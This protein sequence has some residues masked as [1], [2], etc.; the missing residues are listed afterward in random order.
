MKR[1]IRLVRCG[2]VLGCL[3][4]T[5]SL[6][7]CGGGGADVRSDI[8]ATTVGQELLDLQRARDTGVIS[9]EE[10]DRQRKKILERR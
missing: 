8:R 9:Q 2:C 6:V 10:F 7:G 1:W 4:A 3:V 5:V